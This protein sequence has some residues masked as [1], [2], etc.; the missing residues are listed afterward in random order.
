MHIGFVTLESPFETAAG[1]GIAAY[2]R[3]IIPPLVTAGHAVTVITKSNM[4]H[5]DTRSRERVRV[6]RTRLPNTHWYVSKVPVLGTLATLPVRQIEWSFGFLRQMRRAITQDPIDVIESA[7]LGALFLARI[8]TAPLVIRL[9]GSDYTFRKYTGQPLGF[10]SRCSHRLERSTWRHAQ[11]LTAPSRFQAAEVLKEMNWPAE[12]VQ[13]VPNP[14]AAEI[15][16]EAERDQ[17]H[18]EVVRSVPIVLY[19]GRLGPVKGTRPLLEAIRLVQAQVPDVRFVL[20][21]PWQMAEKPAYWGLEETAT[22]QDAPITWLGHVSGQ[23]LM[24][25]YRRANVFVMPSF[26]ESFGISCLEAM[27]FGLPVVASS[28]GGLPEIVEDPQTGLLVPPGRSDQL[29]EAIVRLLRNAPLRQRLGEA[30]QARVRSCFT[31]AK[32]VRRM[33]QVYGEAK[34]NH[35][36][37][38]AC[39]AATAGPKTLLKKAAPVGLTSSIEK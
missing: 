4:A 29:A 6:I 12:R 32:L 5:V 33:L 13:V 10:G 1:G 24:D 31:A 2:L 17:A 26:Y 18:P 3:A 28:A 27:A 23:K 36:R 15:L 34:E 35:C 30:G 20:A 16:T 7:E 21:G 9:H 25:L 39:L 8:S 14:I 22:L 11:A 37:L 19:V 38:R